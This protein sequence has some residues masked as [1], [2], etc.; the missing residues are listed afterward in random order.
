M[1]SFDELTTPVFLSRE[2]HGQRNLVGYSPQ[3][4]K[5]LDTT[6]A[7]YHTRTH[8]MV[9]ATSLDLLAGHVLVPRTQ[10]TRAGKESVVWN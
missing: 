4:C 3:G 8:W 9:K 10:Q 6:E 7:T 5:E 1:V 2:Y